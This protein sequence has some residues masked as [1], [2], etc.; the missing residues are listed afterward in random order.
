MIP[1]E[2]AQAF[3][4]SHCQPRLSE[5]IALADSLGYV[6]SLGI[7]ADSAVPPFANSAM[8]GFAVR[9]ADTAEGPCRLKVVGTLPAGTAP[10]TE[11]GEGE[12][13]RIMT[14]AP[15]PPGADAI[16]VIEDAEVESGGDIV[17]VVKR[18]EPGLHVRPA[19]Q[20]LSP[21]QLVFP[22]GTELGAGH[23]GVLASLGIAELAAYPRPTVGVLSTG[24][25]LVDGPGDLEPGQIRDSNRHTLLALVRQSRLQAVDLGLVR[26]KED[27][28]AAA[29]ERGVAECDVLVTSGGVSMGDLDHVKT[30]LDRLG[31]QS[32]RWMQVA[33]KPAHPLAFGVVS[34][35]PVFGLPG[36]PV[37]A[38]VSFELFVLPALRQMMGHPFPHR[39]RV[40]GVA[41][42]PLPRPR[43][44]KVHFMRVEATYESDGRFHV[45]STGGQASNLLRT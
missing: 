41:D 17:R 39:A 36:N 40:P 9:A 18:V 24:D 33:I 21:G 28:I 42:E 12:A 27:D 37:S 44:G 10:T 31:G 7:F 14:G 6:T 38:M 29:V 16:V 45:K 22:A 8:D 32:M 20:D 35:K 13:I 23:L 3:V 1:L 34:G 11:V 4:L 43:D 26:D 15:A 30:V 5:D 19:G 25:E 2:E